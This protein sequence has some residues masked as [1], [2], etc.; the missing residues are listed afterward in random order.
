MHINKVILCGTLAGAPSVLFT[1]KGTQSA[2]CSLRVQEIGSDGTQYKLFVPLVAYGR[3]AATLGDLSQG[4]T[5][6]IEGRLMWLK[7]AKDSDRPAGLAVFVQSVEV[8]RV[9][10]LTAVGSE[11]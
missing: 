4:D 9:P 11:N 6:L 7:Q 8:E 5:V 3:S 1:E 10:A 2:L